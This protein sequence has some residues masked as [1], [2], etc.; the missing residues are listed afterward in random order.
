MT[1]VWDEWNRGGGP[2]YPHGKVVQFLFRRYPGS[3]SRSSVDVLDLG[4]GSGV[5][6]VLLASE[7]FR[8]HGRDISPVGVANTTQRLAAASLQPASLRVGGVD[9][10]DT[11]DGSFDALFSVGVL[12]CAGPDVFLPALRESVRVLR[13]GG[14][15]MHIFATDR[16]FRLQNNTLGIHGFSDDEVRRA[17]ALLPDDGHVTTLDRLTSTYDGGATVQDEHIVTVRRSNG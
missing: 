12:D 14:A 10:I 4:C 11:D 5:H 8:A 7:G 1:G 9:R 15:A 3:G 2:K 6:M 17:I 16:D 13:P